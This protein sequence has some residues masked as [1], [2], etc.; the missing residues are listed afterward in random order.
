MFPVFL[1][2]SETVRQCHHTVGSYT[3]EDVNAT[4]FF[5]FFFE[6]GRGLN[7]L[8]FGATYTHLGEDYAEHSM[9]NTHPS[10]LEEDP[11]ATYDL[12]TTWILWV[13]AMVHG[14]EVSTDKSKIM[15]NST[16]NI[17][18][19]ISMNGKKLEEVT[20]LSTLEKPCAKM[21]P[22][23]QESASGLPQQRQQ[24]LNRT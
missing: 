21:A 11:Y 8:C 14:M 4:T 18:A 5:F 16:K 10:P 13:A 22:A 12:P 7:V 23:Q 19:D 20:S 24:W 6:G 9:T 1:Q 3:I 2:Y 15:T 17:S